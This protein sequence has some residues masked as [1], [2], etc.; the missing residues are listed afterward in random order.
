MTEIAHIYWVL[1]RYQTICSELYIS[2]VQTQQH[3][4]LL[5]EIEKTPTSKPSSP[6]I[7]F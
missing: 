6:D 4:E 1:L 7:L 3:T 2:G 5:R